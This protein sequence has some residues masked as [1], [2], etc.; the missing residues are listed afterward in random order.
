MKT[1]LAILGLF[2][3]A[4]WLGLTFAAPAP[5]SADTLSTSPIAFVSPTTVNFGVVY[6]GEFATNSVMV[7]NVGHGRLMGT[8]TVE[9]PFR[10]LSGA[11]YKLDRSAAQ[12]VTIVYTPSGIPTNTAKL[13]FTGAANEVSV[14]L[15]GRLSSKQRPYHWKRK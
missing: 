10:I 5:T 9:P 15:V 14:T 1:R 3:S 13:K 8:A 4:P 11:N 2:L 7:E 12:V 6:D